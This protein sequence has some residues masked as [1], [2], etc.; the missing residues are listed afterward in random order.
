VDRLFKGRPVMPGDFEGSALV[1]HQG[2]NTLASFYQSMLAHADQA[3]CS[4]QGNRDL[5]QK[6]L[7]GKVICIPK[8][9]GSTSAGAT[10]DRV[11]SMGIAPQGILFSEFIDS[12]SAAGLV[13]ADLWAGRRVFAVDQL[14]PEFL[15][16]VQDGCRVCVHQDGS[17]KVNR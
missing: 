4:D 13:L 8:C 1:T 7:T 14:G 15:D 9:V 6:N 17:V 3:V 2:F 11:A 12:L 5:C 10:W 16:F